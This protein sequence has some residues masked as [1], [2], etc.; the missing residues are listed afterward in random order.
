MTLI[1]DLVIE[2]FVSLAEGIFGVVG[3]FTDEAEADRQALAVWE[4]PGI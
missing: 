3:H 1:V 2:F 4:R